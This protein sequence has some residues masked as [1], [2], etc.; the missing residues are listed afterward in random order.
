[1]V[2]NNDYYKK[3]INGIRSSIKEANSDIKLIDSKELARAHGVDKLGRTNL[4]VRGM[5]ELE[6]PAKIF[7]K[8]ISDIKV[9]LNKSKVY[10]VMLDSE[11]RNIISDM[12]TEWQSLSD[13]LDQFKA[14]GNLIEKKINASR[15]K[16]EMIKIPTFD[17]L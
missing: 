2:P 11:L 17:N 4:R 6:H 5:Y 12:D 3:I 8:Y 10:V 13:E 16:R 7:E 9:P 1:M 15:F 14:I